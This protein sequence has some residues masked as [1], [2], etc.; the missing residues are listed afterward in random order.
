MRWL[1]VHSTIQ[2][3]TGYCEQS[4]NYA[5]TTKGICVVDQSLGLMHGGENVYTCIKY[6][7]YVCMYV[8]LTP[9]SMHLL[10]EN[11]TSTNRNYIHMQD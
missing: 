4:G 2:D 10:T 6:L 8:Y 3:E 5:V 1:E 11:S 9:V 7:M